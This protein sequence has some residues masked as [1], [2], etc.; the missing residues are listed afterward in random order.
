MASSAIQL[1]APVQA[2]II[3]LIIKHDMHDMPSHSGI[4]GAHSAIHKTNDN[5]TLSSTLIGS[6]LN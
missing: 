1:S 3:K 2:R 5:I 4:G 6:N